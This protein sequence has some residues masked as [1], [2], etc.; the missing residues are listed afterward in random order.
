M[1]YVEGYID[2]LLYP[3]HSDSH[4]RKLPI[5]FA[6][7]LE[8]R[9]FDLDQ[10]RRILRNAKEVSPKQHRFAKRLVEKRA[11]GGQFTLHHTPFLS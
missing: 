10:Y 7:G 6:F 5:Y 9:A 11:A 1:S 8:G 3:L 2:G 4:R